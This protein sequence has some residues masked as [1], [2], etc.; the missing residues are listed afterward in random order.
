MNVCRCNHDFNFIIVFGKGN[1]VLNYYITNYITKTSNYT[2]H[3]YLLMKIGV[4]KFKKLILK[5]FQKTKFKEKSSFDYM[6]TEYNWFSTRYL[7]NKRYSYL[8]KFSN[9]I[10]NMYFSNNPSSLSMWVFEQESPLDS[11][12][13]D[14]NTHE[15][16]NTD[17]DIHLHQHI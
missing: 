16:F 1:E 7:P 2:S 3:M 8:M 4:Q 17:K 9:H 11:I 12:R 14:E 13:G 5:P 15:C 10:M 6:V